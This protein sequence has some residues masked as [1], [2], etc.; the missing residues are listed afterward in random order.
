MSLDENKA[1]ARA[2]TGLWSTGELDRAGEIFA[3]GY[4]MHQ[5]HDPD[6]SGDLG[7]EAMK[8]FAAEFRRG[9]PDFRDTIDLQVAEGE[10]VATRFTSTGTHRGEFMGVAPTGLRLSWTGGDRPRGRRPDRRGLGQLGHD[11]HA[12]AAG[13]QPGRA[14]AGLRR[15]GTDRVAGGSGCELPATAC[16]GSDAR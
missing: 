11:G 15:R 2:A 6:G 8:A 7:V 16:L 13:C 9:F 4:V 10:L 5:H 14:D 1:L 3:P 12:A